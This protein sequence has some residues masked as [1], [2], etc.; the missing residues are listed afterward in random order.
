MSHARINSVSFQRQV[1]IV[2]DISA[3]QPFSLP[4]RTHI[5]VTL[6]TLSTVRFPNLYGQLF[7]FR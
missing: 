1:E 5:Y 2:S 7:A 3:K 6:A 4:Q